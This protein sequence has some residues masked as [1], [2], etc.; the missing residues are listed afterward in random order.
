MKLSKTSRLGSSV[1]KLSSQ[2]TGVI[3][4]IGNNPHGLQ[5]L[6][7]SNVSRRALESLAIGGVAQQP[8]LDADKIGLFLLLLLS[9]SKLYFSKFQLSKWDWTL[10]ICLCWNI[11]LLKNISTGF[12]IRDST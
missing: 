7:S 2:F 12:V 5:S 4:E 3:N 8:S 1:I 10:F 11:P 6:S 9:R